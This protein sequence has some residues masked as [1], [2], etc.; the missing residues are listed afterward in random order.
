M[1]TELSTQRTQATVGEVFGGDPP[2]EALTYLRLDQIVPSRW[3]P[4]TVFDAE[5]LHN[6]ANDIRTHG[7]LNPVLAWRNEDQEYELIA[8]ERRVRS[9][10]ALVLDATG[11]PGDLEKLIGELAQLGFIRW[12]ENVSERLKRPSCPIWLRTIPCRVVSADPATLHEIAI[13]DNLQR[14]DLSPL[15]EAHALQ[16][17]VEEHG[18]SQRQLGERLGKSQTWISQRLTLLRLSSEVADQVAA[19]ELDPATARE[20]ARLEPAVQAAAIKHMQTKALKSKAGQNLVQKIIEYADPARWAP[21]GPGPL[22]AVRRLIRLSL[23]RLDPAGRQAAI[24]KYA[25]YGSTGTF[26]VPRFDYEYR[27]MLGS[28]GLHGSVEALWNQHAPA[29]NMTCA[30]CQFNSHRAEIAA[31]R[32]LIISHSDYVAGATNCPRCSPTAATC[33]AWSPTGEPVRLPISWLPDPFPYAED[34]RPHVIGNPDRPEAIADVTAWAAILRRKYEIK[35]AREVAS[36]EREQNGVATALAGYIAAQHTIRVDHFLSH[37]CA[38]CI[39][40]RAGDDVHPCQ[41]L[42]TQPKV[43]TYDNILAR[44]WQ[45]GN[46]VIGR[47]RFYRLRAP[48]QALPDLPGAGIGLTPEA[49]L[50]LLRDLAPGYYGGR[51]VPSW[52]DVKRASGQSAPSWTDAE[53]VLQKLL[54]ILTPGQRLALLYL[55]LPHFGFQRPGRHRELATAE[56]YV[57]DQGRV[58]TYEVHQDFAA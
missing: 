41:H 19:G 29:A 4:R 27:W 35:D 17:L 20:I 21:D 10:Y 32:D 24:L 26:S 2:G 8:G 14:A 58:I 48:H 33:P 37:A 22:A 23:E 47:C 45:S 49:M 30:T 52:L 46:T 39:F 43:E 36:A 56:A 11:H 38:T 28:T 42:A 40:H 1:T 44:T 31:V 57:P 3:Q 5:R 54:P 51:H 6:L 25:G 18:Y 13:V 12:R 15:E 34:E 55:W 16:A 7:L 53:P 50:L 9:L